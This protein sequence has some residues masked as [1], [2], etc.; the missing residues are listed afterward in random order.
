MYKSPF[1]HLL[2]WTSSHFFLINTHTETHHLFSLAKS[3]RKHETEALQDQKQSP[4]VRSFI[5]AVESF[6]RPQSCS[7]TNTF[8]CHFDEHK[9]R[10]DKENRIFFPKLLFTLYF[11]MIFI[12]YIVLVFSQFDH[13]NPIQIVILFQFNFVCWQNCSFWH[14][15][16]SS[17]KSNFPTEKRREKELEARPDEM[18]WFLFNFFACATKMHIFM[19]DRARRIN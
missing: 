17:K 9:K 12:P 1:R 19:D 16:F 6:Q 7:Q 3:I 15:F 10:Q 11:T 8:R 5:R 2:L 14:F 4:H 13:K 18:V